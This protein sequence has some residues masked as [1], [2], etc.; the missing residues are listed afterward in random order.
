VPARIF[1]IPPGGSLSPDQ[2]REA[3][4]AVKACKIAAFP[5]DTVYG[6]GTNGLIKAGLRRIYQIKGRDSMKPL[7]ILVK[8][9]EEAKRWVEWTPEAQALARRF[10]PGALTLSLRPT[11][12]GRLL[13]F[14]EFP[15]LAI[16]VP[17]HP[18]ALALLEAADV[19]LASTSANLSGKPAL[20]SGGDV[21]S[22]FENLVDLII[23]AGPAGGVESTVVDAT[24][25][26]ARVLREGRISK[27]QILAA[28][29]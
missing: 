9:L 17:A 6:L 11:K 3:G 12:E 8:S 14:P 21:A 2:A 20:S 5:T 19:P 22:A 27:D 28:R 15:T 18:V 13:T 26:P 10:W 23:D 29:A 25:S 24:S 1:S 7:P 4:A 16:R